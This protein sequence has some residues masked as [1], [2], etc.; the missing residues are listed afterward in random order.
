MFYHS[1]RPNSYLSDCLPKRYVEGCF[2]TSDDLGIDGV[3]EIQAFVV[4]GGCQGPL[5]P[6]AEEGTMS[7]LL[8]EQD[9]APG[10]GWNTG[11]HQWEMLRLMVF[12][13][14]LCYRCQSLVLTPQNILPVYL[15]IIGA[16]HLLV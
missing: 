8:R 7:A 16:S 12:C 15:F 10:P 2:L 3:E 11:E 6:N 5:Q 9:Q 14:P 1:K 4:H 13:E